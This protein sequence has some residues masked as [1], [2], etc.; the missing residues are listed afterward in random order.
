M[1]NDEIL[2]V[3]DNILETVG[4]DCE[5]IILFAAITKIAPECPKGNS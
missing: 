1:V 5:K 4:E 3:K 2:A